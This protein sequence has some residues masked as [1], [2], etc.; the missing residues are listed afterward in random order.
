[1]V[2]RPTV[3]ADRPADERPLDRARDRPG[4]LART[5]SPVRPA[6]GPSGGPVASWRA[7]P[8]RILAPIIYIPELPPAD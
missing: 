8:V 1:M 4:S 2:E 6:G 5:R 7:W 3:H